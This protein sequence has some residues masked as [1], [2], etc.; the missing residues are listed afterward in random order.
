[1]GG[2][3]INI[4]MRPVQNL[5]LENEYVPEPGARGKWDI[6]ENTTPSV[7]D[8]VYQD[9][10]EEHIAKAKTK[11]VADGAVTIKNLSAQ[12]TA[13]LT[14]K[15]T[16]MLFSKE[17]LEDHMEERISA[18]L[19]Q[20]IDCYDRDLHYTVGKTEDQTKS[21]SA[22]NIQL[23]PGIRKPPADLKI[24]FASAHHGTL[25][26]IYA[27]PRA[28]WDAWKAHHNV[29]APGKPIG[30]IHSN[31]SDTYYLNNACTGLET[32]INQADIDLDGNPTEKMIEFGRRKSDNER[33]LREFTIDLLNKAAKKEITPVQGLGLYIDRLKT[34]LDQLVVDNPTGERHLIFSTWKDVI[35]DLEGRYR[36]NYKLFIAKLLHIHVPLGDRDVLNIEE[37][38]YPRHFKMLQRKNTYQTEL[39]FRVDTLKKKILEGVS[40]T[41]KNFDKAFK[42]ALMKEAFVQDERIRIIFQRFYNCSGQTLAN[43]QT[44][45][46]KFKP[47]IRLVEGKDSKTFIRE[48]FVNFSKYIHNFSIDEAKFSSGLVKEIRLIRGLSLRTFSKEH[49]RL[50]PQAHPLNHEQLRR[51]EL[52]CV[53]PT[54]GMI[55]RMARVLNIHESILKADLI[56]A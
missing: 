50:F 19:M 7:R 45:C 14:N 53:K 47:A 22:I 20:I 55:E 10:R 15:C 11:K 52:G 34:L 46:D 8:A 24:S 44:E 56:S 48:F 26:C 21:T 39:A 16:R 31:K 38:I 49:N 25:P 30:K 28:E 13:V 3:H 32:I 29:N 41:P 35:V 9:F 17:A 6:M 18:F 33:K 43:L 4:N 40:N 36:G 1:M 54:T 27:Y 2:P 23:P 37:M 42:L 5:P 51:I 12:E